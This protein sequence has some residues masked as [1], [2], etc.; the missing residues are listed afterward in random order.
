MK[1]PKKKTNVVVAEVEVETEKATK[2]SEAASIVMADA[3]VAVEKADGIQ[4][5]CDTELA[6]NLPKLKEAQKAVD[7]LDKKRCNRTQGIQFSTSYIRYYARSYY[8]NN[9]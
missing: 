8:V 4:K 5:N 6:K 3:D 2:D 7:K 9:R 1:L